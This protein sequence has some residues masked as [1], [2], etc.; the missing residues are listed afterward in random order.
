MRIKIT[1][2]RAEMECLREYLSQKYELKNISKPVK[3]RHSE[4][5]R[6]YLTIKQK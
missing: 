5:Y 4:N 6:Q 2:S 1:S 3:N